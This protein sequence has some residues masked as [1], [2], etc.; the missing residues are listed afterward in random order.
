MCGICGI[1]KKQKIETDDIKKVGLMNKKLDKRGPDDAGFFNDEQIAIAMRRLSIIDIEGGNQPLYNEDKTIILVV[2]GEIY[3]YVE[4]RDDL[5]KQG[6]LF[7]TESDCETIVH[8][9]EEYGENFLNYLRGMFSLCLYDKKRKKIILARDRIGEK[10]LYILKEG[11]RITFS[12]EMKSIITALPD[13]EIKIDNDSLRLFFYYRYVPEP[14]TMIKG[15]CKL[16]AGKFMSID[17][18]DFTSVIKPYWD[19]NE[20]KEKITNPS[21]AIKNRLE[22]IEQIIIRSDVPVGISLSGGID[23]SLISVLSHK[24]SPK[25]LHAFCVGY[26]GYPENDERL[27]AAKLAAQLELKFHDIQI[28]NNE[29]E[30]DFEKIVYLMDDPIADIAAYGYYRVAKKAREENVPVLL[31][32]FGGD[33]LFWGYEWAVKAVKINKLKQRRTGK[34]ILFLL[35]LKN[36]RKLLIHNPVKVIRSILQD[37]ANDKF[38]LFDF[39]YSFKRMGAQEKD[40]FTKDF[41]SLTEADLPH[42]LGITKKE[43]DPSVAATI[44]LIKIWMQS[45]CIPLGDR[46]SMANSVELRLPLLDYKLIEDVVGLRKQSSNDYKLGYK[47]WLIDAAKHLLSPEIINRQKQGFNPPSEEWMNSVVNKYS[48]QIMNGFLIRNNILNKNYLLSSLNSA[49]PNKEFLYKVVLMEVW[50]KIFLKN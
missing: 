1:I 35:S 39:E 45:N 34:M 30:S 31:S 26:P 44:N 37:I 3:N 43:I 21:D 9:Y 8:A 36:L 14:R 46:L 27:K 38:N 17:L 49:R 48:S 4:L 15:I 50:L 24:Y 19:I 42:S 40:V 29:F 18:N 11:G 47:K 41:L 10:P 6:H 12:S 13:D 16:P 23:S 33:E 20:I 28:T 2:N 25:K 7:N 32:G 5:K 22:E